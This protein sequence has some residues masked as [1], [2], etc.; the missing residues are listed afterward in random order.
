MDDPALRERIHCFPALMLAGRHAEV[1]AEA[2]QLHVVGAGDTFAR[3]L[4]FGDFA[5]CKARRALG[6]AACDDEWVDT[7]PLPEPPFTAPAEGLEHLDDASAHYAEAQKTAAAEDERLETRYYQK[8][9]AN[10][11]RRV[12]ALQEILP[13]RLA[14]G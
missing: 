10:R 5:L 12:Q 11:E 13:A 2:G 14:T 8:T 1:E 3:L 6:M 4:F 9:L 7:P